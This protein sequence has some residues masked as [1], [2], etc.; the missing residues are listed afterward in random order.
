MAVVTS[1]MVLSLPCLECKLFNGQEA[2]WMAVQK[3]KIWPWVAFVV[4]ALTACGGGG[5]GGSSGS[6]STSQSVSGDQTYFPLPS[7]A[8]W[9]YSLDDGGSIRVDALGS[10]ATSLGLGTQIGTSDQNGHLLDK[11]IVI[12]TGSAVAAY[13]SEKLSSIVPTLGSVK[14][15][16]YPLQAG[17]SFTQIDKTLVANLDIDQDGENDE[18][19]IRSTVYVVGYEEIDT[20]AG[21]FSHVV[22]LRT[23]TYETFVASSDKKAYP[24]RNTVDDWYAPGV[25]LVRSIQTHYPDGHTPTKPISKVLVAYR[26]DG[27]RSEYVPPSVIPSVPSGASRPDKADLAV[28][29]SEPVDSATLDAGL[30]VVDSYGTLLSGHVH[31]DGVT[32]HFIPDSGWHN[33]TYVATLDTSVTDLIGN[34]LSQPVTW[35]FTVDAAVPSVISTSP[36]NNSSAIASFTPLLVQFNEPIDVAISSGLNF[37]VSDGSNSIPVTTE[38]VGATLK[39]IPANGWPRQK[40]IHVSLQN[41]RDI[42]GNF[43]AGPYR[44]SFR[45]DPGEFDYP[46]DLAGDRDA[47]SVVIKDLDRDGVLDFIFTGDSDQVLR[48]VYVRYGQLG[49]G[50]V[51]PVPL[52]DVDIADC[53]LINLK[54]VTL[55]NDSREDVLASGN[56]GVRLIRQT[57]ARRFELGEMINYV[58]TSPQ[59]IDL[60]KDGKLELVGMANLVDGQFLYVWRE[61]R[62]GHYTGA[63]ARI[64]LPAESGAL[65]Q[66]ADLDGDSLPDLLMNGGGLTG[67]DIKVLYQQLDGTFVQK[68]T[69]QTGQGRANGMALGDVNGDGLPD[70]V[71]T[72]DG[73]ST[74]YVAVFHQQSDHSFGEAERLPCLDFPSAVVLADLNGDGRQDIIVMHSGWGHVGTFLQQANGKMAAESLYVSAYGSSLQS[75]AVGDLTGDGRPDISLDGQLLRQRTP[76]SGPSIPMH[77][78]MLAHAAQLMNRSLLQ[79]ND[80]GRFK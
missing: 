7:N 10:Q 2:G 56:C 50:L 38:V 79:A 47:Q 26:L 68:Q 42:S 51:A 12:A 78:P 39:I 35:S 33:G 31:V 44:L 36:A 30:R 65:I 40:T 80:L 24:Y 74:R 5:S 70:I 52:L 41:I 9:I 73:N 45:S 64:S 77:A 11:S 43:M 25:G 18:L 76:D 60:D 19:S 15:F 3:L 28:T 54:V 37:T 62:T 53:G 49:G 34:P 23:D 8:R 16:S 32:A 22:H 13:P 58:L 27:V 57:A 46:M 6:E 48:K 17:S 66:I 55:G 61:D 1:D 20:P 59:V 71:A 69:L 4:L 21:H 72:A 75:L 14:L 29:F 63:P 67:Q